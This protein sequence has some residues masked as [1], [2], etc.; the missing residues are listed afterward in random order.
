M[1]QRIWPARLAVVL[2]ACCAAAQS[3]GSV[4]GRLVDATGAA[5]RNVSIVLRLNA[6][7]AEF[8]QTTA[9]D[10]TF[11]FG[12]VGAGEYLLRAR[13]EGFTED[14][15]TIRIGS[16]ELE[17]VDIQLQLAILAQ[18]VVIHAHELAGGGVDFRGIPGAVSRIDAATLTQSRAFTFDEALR[19]VPGV[20]T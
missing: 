11:R 15:R 5:I 4:A 12:G 3:T 19:M 20:Y 17:R 8:I 10:G 13:A 14:Q 7:G 9:T 6:T 16:G 18:Q 2:L 1:I